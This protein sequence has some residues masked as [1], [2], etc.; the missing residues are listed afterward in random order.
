MENS[1]KRIFTSLALILVFQLI[2]IKTNE[3]QPLPYKAWNII[4]H[5]NTGYTITTSD[6]EYTHP[7]VLGN[8]G[9]FTGR[10][11]GTYDESS[12]YYVGLECSKGYFGFQANIGISPAKFL[13]KEQ[14]DP[15]ITQ[16]R[17]DIYSFNILFLEAEG[18][19]FP[20][21]NSIN[22]IAPFI[23]AGLSYMSTSGDI[24]NNLLAFSG[25]I[26]VRTFFTGSLGIDFSLKAKYMLLYNVP[27]ADQISAAYGVSLSSLSANVG[28]LCRL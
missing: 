12:I 24:H 9:S 8:G 5:F 1:M 3:A 16:T 17:N 25:S 19:L 26:G 11:S 6:W 14:V 10:I 23:K 15:G 13:I 22:K 2:I 27:L 7:Y 4:L 28:I 20:F 18:M 21:G